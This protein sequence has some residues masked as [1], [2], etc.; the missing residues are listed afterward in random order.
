TAHDDNQVN[1]RAIDRLESELQRH[2]LYWMRSHTANNKEFRKQL[3]KTLHALRIEHV[4]T[5]EQRELFVDGATIVY[6]LCLIE[7]GGAWGYE[8][9]DVLMSAVMSVQPPPP[10][11]EVRAWKEKFATAQ[12]DI[13]DEVAQENE[14]RLEAYLENELPAAALRIQKAANY[15]VALEI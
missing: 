6:R 14:G 9:G 7:D 12:R 5:P 8:L 2:I 11:A 10:E 3:K 4:P 15:P 13:I 1:L